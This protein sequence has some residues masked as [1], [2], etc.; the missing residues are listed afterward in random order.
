MKFDRERMKQELLARAQES[1][2]S[3]DDGGKFGKYLSSDFPFPWWKCGEGEH[4]LDILLF[5]AGEGYPTKSHIKGKFDPNRYVYWLDIW[6]HFNIGANQDSAA[7]P[8]MSFGLPCPICEDVAYL[9]KQKPVDKEL[10]DDIKAKRR[11]GY[12]IICYDS[13]AEERKGIQYFDAAHFYMEKHLSARARKPF[14]G[15]HV[16]FA[17]PWNGKQVYFSKTGTRLN[18]EFTGH[19]FLDRDY[20]IHDDLLAKIVSPADYIVRHEYDELKKMYLGSGSSAPTQERQQTTSVNT[21]S[22]KEEPPPQTEEDMPPEEE[23]KE[24]P[25]V[26][27]RTRQPLGQEEPPKEEPQK[28]DSPPPRARRAM[29]QNTTPKEEPQKQQSVVDCPGK[30]VFGVDIDKLTACG[31]CDKWDDCAVESQRLE[32]EKKQAGGSSRRAR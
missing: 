3:R 25:P 19:Q 21:R 23:V 31:V 9:N 29:P 32:N 30:G 26:R 1:Y 18:T 15:G 2:E 17:D 12:L 10:I 14:G 4:V 13:E 20:S 11:S 8:N 28:E 6:V 7:C 27:T 22:P 5:E 16:L 24:D